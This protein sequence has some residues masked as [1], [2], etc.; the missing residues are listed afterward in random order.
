MYRDLTHLGKCGREIVEEG[1]FVLGVDFNNLAE[2]G[3]LGEGEVRR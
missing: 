3:V 2:L 1:L